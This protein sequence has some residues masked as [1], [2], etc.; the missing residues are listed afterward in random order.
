VSAVERP[1]LP[2]PQVAAQVRQHLPAGLAAWLVGGAV[3]DALLHRPVSDFDFVLAGDAL[4]AARGLA[5]ALGGAYY[6]LDAERGVGRVVLAGGA[7]RLTLDL[8]NLRGPDLPADLAA[9]DFTLNALAIDLG[10]PGALIDPLHGERD[11]RAKLIRQ[12]SPRAMA[13][14]PLRAIRAV[15]L[16]AELRF[17]IEPETLAAVRGQAQT[18]AAVSAERRRDEL[19]RCLG[20]PRP[21]AAIRSLDRLGLLPALLPELSALHGV[22]QSPPHVFDVWEHTLTVLDRLVEVLAA[23][24]PVYN[25]DAVSDVTL[26][27]AS[28]RLGRHRQALGGHLAASLNSD[29]PLRTLV[30]L[31]SLLHDVGKAATRTVEPDGRIRFFDHENVGARL[32]QVRL[33]ELRLSSEEA[34]RVSAIVAQ[35][36]RPRSLASE[37]R[38]SRRAI[39]RFFQQAG[40]AG[41]DVVLLSLADFLGTYGDS[42][43]PTDEWNRLLSV[44]SELLRA[45]FETPAE[46]VRPPTLLTGDDLQREFALKPGPEIGQI[47]AEL[48]EAQAAGEVADRPAAL[49]WVRRY[50]DNGRTGTTK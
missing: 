40:P 22:T 6:P 35:H 50:L 28:M 46:V 17:R 16:G 9:R 32:A 26:G 23:L 10:Q 27:L 7:T 47:L 45:Y 18:V 1:T 21:G 20:G 33:S 25:I 39:Y 24:D 49:E 41:V 3:R 37:P 8:S 11:L 38:V 19:L 44:C 5:N 31:A 43:P 48:R 15:R 34:A 14:D 36:M 2:L 4:A 42:P 29:H 30:L 13:D 12:C